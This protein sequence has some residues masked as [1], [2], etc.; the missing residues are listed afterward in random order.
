M[1]LMGPLAMGRLIGTDGGRRYRGGSPRLRNVRRTH[2]WEILAEVLE[3]ED[4]VYLDVQK[5]GSSTI[6]RFLTSHGRGSIVED[7]K[8]APVRSKHPRKTYFISCRDPLK[9]YISLYSYGLGLTSSGGERRE[10]GAIRGYMERSGMAGVYDG[11]PEGFSAWMDLVLDPAIGKEVFGG[12]ASHP[13]LGTIGLQSL[14]FATLN[15]P[16]P[17][18]ELAQLTSVED[19]IDSL[20]CNGLAD[21]VLRTETLSAQLREMCDGV[22][23]DIIANPDRARRRLDMM[24]PINASIDLGLRPETLPRSLRLRVQRRDRLF[25]DLLGYEP[26]V[27]ENGDV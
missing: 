26:Y 20:A 6:R 18:H 24:P 9:Q 7:Q 22:Y 25:F 5:T 17:Q 12:R 4:F 21:V 1:L 8:H 16:S 11:T 3:F 13:L 19:V 23:G 15:L 14:R 2:R 10:R 27:S